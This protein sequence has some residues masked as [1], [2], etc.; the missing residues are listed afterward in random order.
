MQDDEIG[1]KG[2]EV[3]GG[4]SGDVYKLKSQRGEGRPGSQA[5]GAPRSDTKSK[6]S[7]MELMLQEMKVLVHV[8]L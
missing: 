7:N 4:T 5:S 6:L 2:K 1:G 3:F 8:Y